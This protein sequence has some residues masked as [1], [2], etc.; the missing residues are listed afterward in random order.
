AAGIHP[1][2][3]RR[4]RRSIRRRPLPNHPQRG[5]CR[6]LPGRQRHRRRA[7]Q[8]GGL[9][10]HRGCLPARDGV[11]RPRR[12]ARPHR[13]PAA[14]VHR[15][16]AGERLGHPVR[17][18]SRGAASDPLSR[19]EAGCRPEADR[20]RGARAAP[21]RHRRAPSPPRH[22][23]PDH[24]RDAGDVPRPG[25]AQAAV[26]RAGEAVAPRH[27]LLYPPG[28]RHDRRRLDRA[29]RG[30]AGERLHARHTRQ[31]PGRAS[32]AL[33]AEGLADLRRGRRGR[34][35]RRRTPQARQPAPLP[36]PDP[37]RHPAEPITPPPP[38]PPDP[39]QAGEHRPDR[40]GGAPRR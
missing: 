34:G 10:R 16:S 33:P 13:W 6:W 8:G 32:P 30:A 31:P 22:D 39:L 28:R 35:G 26:D 17:G 37:P 14:R 15:R 36:W 1:L 9:P 19:P 4:C 25:S 3:R 2:A 23:Q 21:R 24:G 27:R 38:G 20:L 11:G 29:G 18:Q 7:V 12:V 5:R 40:G